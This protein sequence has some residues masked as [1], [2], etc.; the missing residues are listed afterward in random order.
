MRHLRWVTRVACGE[1]ASFW[2]VKCWY[3]Q[4][5]CAHH[6]TCEKSGENTW[7]ERHESSNGMLWRM[8]AY[9]VRRMFLFW[10][11]TQTPV[12]TDKMSSNFCKRTLRCMHGCHRSQMPKCRRNAWHKQTAAA[13]TITSDEWKH[14]QTLKWF[15]TLG[16]RYWTRWLRYNVVA[17][18]QKI[19]SMKWHQHTTNKYT[20]IIRT[21][22]ANWWHIA[23]KCIAL[24]VIFLSGYFSRT[25]THFPAEGFAAIFFLFAFYSHSHTSKWRA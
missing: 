5:V 18:L 14:K 16:W 13:A 8:H 4:A 23:R 6:R 12:D 7:Y 1:K 9:L 22:T 10:F 15:S 3:I 25:H 19:W 20:V 24:K 11:N 2:T 21:H 17:A